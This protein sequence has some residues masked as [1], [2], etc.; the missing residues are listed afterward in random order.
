MR[1][2]LTL[3]GLLL[4]VGG[5]AAVKGSQIGSLIAFGEEAQAAGPP[6]EP[7]GTATAERTTLEGVLTAVGSVASAQGVAVSTEVPGVVTD[8]RFES[9]ARVRAGDVL[10][11]LDT[12]V[13]RA[14][15]AQAMA[16]KQ[17]AELTVERSRT[18]VSR[19]AL[20][21]QQQDTDESELK[22]ATAQVDMLRAQIALKTI[23]APFDGTL[24]IRQINLGQYLSPGTAVA[25]LETDK[26]LYVDFTLPQQ[27][28]TEVKEG[29]PIR[30]TVGSRS[31]PPLMGVIAAIE[32]AVDASTRQIR[33]RGSVPDPSDFLRPGMFVEVSVLLG[34]GAPTVIVPITAVVFASYGDSV[35][36]VEDKAAEAPG[37]RETPDGKPVRTA[38]Q[39]FVKTG[40]QRGDFVEITA[41]VDEGTEVV[42]AGAFKLR[43]GAPI[44]VDN[45]VLPSPSLNPE[46][47]NR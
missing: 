14:Q 21:T 18:L 23:R 42:I 40:T 11:R 22:S 47:Q 33:L 34:E 29:M 39:Q 37:M 31:G 24:G 4:V 32:P 36:I 30:V 7:V 45:R 12:K 41:G 3:F 2:V 5:L 9:G 26:S 35:F 28:A 10:V 25:E 46:V 6:P 13:E 27:R 38:R 19:G 8:L 16:R 15:L 17:L 1:Y 43:N 20:S 44:V